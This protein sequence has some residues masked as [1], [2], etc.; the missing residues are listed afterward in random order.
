VTSVESTDDVNITA[1]ECR[2]ATNTTNILLA[3]E[4]TK[5]SDTTWSAGND[6]GGLNAADFAEDSDGLAPD[7]TYHVFLI[8]HTDGTVDAGLDKGTAAINLRNDSGYTYY[9]RV[10]SVVTD[11]TAAP[12]A[13][14][15]P[16]FQVGH[17]FW[18]KTPGTE[19]SFATETEHTA[20]TVTLTD[21]PTGYK[22]LFYMN[23][24]LQNTTEAS[25]YISSLEGAD[26]NAI[27][28][29]TPFATITAYQAT[30]QNNQLQCLVHSNASAQ[31]RLNVHETGGGTDV[32]SVGF[33]L[34]GWRDDLGEFE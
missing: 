5:K 28:G 9:R 30:S 29:S 31:F 12:N 1:G 24:H 13:N 33:V 7:T 3:S 19:L 21:A 6:A 15:I 17:N 27:I 4:M 32:T 34:L 10:G 22:F 18:L 14:L 25:A 8:K 20:R 23:M 16:W 26:V 11:A 2:D